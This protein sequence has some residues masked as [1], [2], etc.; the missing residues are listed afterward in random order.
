MGRP[1]S[2][3][4]PTAACQIVFRGFIGWLPEDIRYQGVI[5]GMLLYYAPDGIPWALG[6]GG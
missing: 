5:M 3:G 6:A 1:T 4:K 2:P